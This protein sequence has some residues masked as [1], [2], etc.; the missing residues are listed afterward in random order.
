M[1]ESFQIKIYFDD[2]TLSL[3]FLLDRQFLFLDSQSVYELTNFT[4]VCFPIKD[5]PSPDL[6]GSVREV[7]RETQY[8]IVCCNLNLFSSNH[9]FSLGERQ[10]NLAM[11]WS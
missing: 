11:W 7:V 1:K 5:H 6:A 4:R 8:D 2:L 9:C 10:A 3:L